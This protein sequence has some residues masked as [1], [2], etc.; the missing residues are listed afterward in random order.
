MG[1]LRRKGKSLPMASVS[2]VDP[3][4]VPVTFTRLAVVQDALRELYRALSPARIRTY[5]AAIAPVVTA[6]TEPVI[7]AQRLARAIALHLG[8]TDVRLI[9]SF[10]E[11]GETG[12][13]GY[14]A[15]NV[16]LG[17][18]P[19][20]FI[21]LSP[22]FRDDVR[23]AAAVLAHEVMHVFLHRNRIWWKD[24]DRNEI[25]TDTA[26]VYLGTGWLMLDAH[27]VEGAGQ[28]FG[29]LSPAELGYVLAKRALA[30]DED[31][32]RYLA[33]NPAARQAYRAGRR[34]A[35]Q[36]HEGA[37][38][39]GCQRDAHRQ[40]LADRRRAAHLA[41]PSALSGPALP[42][43]GG[44]R[45]EGHAPMKVVFGCPTC[46]QRIRVPVDRTATVRCATCRSTHAVT[47]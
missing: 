21:T 38:L 29:Y 46:H 14:H 9:V 27:R 13:G 47:T 10:Q 23:G 8:M 31:I 45:F 34:R 6:W 24:Q 16:E 3:G 41:T 33:D 32:E 15:G 36:D 26:M 12:D 20:Y 5:T 44:Y 25:L 7:D 19:E 30:F 22:R 28:S 1:F 40:Y 42:F 2:A 4:V 18:G 11:L 39:S 43:D 17:P 35:A 37:P